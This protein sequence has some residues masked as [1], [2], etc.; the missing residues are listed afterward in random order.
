MKD[1]VVIV[2]GINIILIFNEF[3]IM[4]CICGIGI[5]GDNLGLE[6]FVGIV[7]NGVLCVCNGVG[8]NDF[9]EFECIEVLCGL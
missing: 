8:F 3:V 2:L 4:V 7:I 6:S 1:L 5:V 9:G